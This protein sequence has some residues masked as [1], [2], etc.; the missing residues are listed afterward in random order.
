MKVPEPVSSGPGR[1]QESNRGIIPA[2]EN[3]GHQSKIAVRRL[4]F[5]DRC[6]PS[7]S[8]VEP[9]AH[10]VDGKRQD[11]IELARIPVGPPFGSC[12]VNRLEYCS[13]AGLRWDL[14]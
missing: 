11:T 8:E 6:F 1:K 13:I 12:S 4:A 9:A 14:R 3:Y 2:D 10:F 5:R 7:C